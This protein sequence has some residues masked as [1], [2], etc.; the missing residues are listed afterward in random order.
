LRLYF[1]A[2]TT[3]QEDRVF[4]LDRLP[5]GVID[6]RRWSPLTKIPIFLSA[7]GLA[8]PAIQLGP[9]TILR[10]RPLYRY[11]VE[12]ASAS[13]WMR[14]AVRFPL[15]GLPRHG[16]ELSSDA[17]RFLSSIRDLCAAK[18]VRIA[19]S[20]P[21]ALVPHDEA[22]AFRRSNARFLAKVSRF[23][24]VLRDDKLGA[25]SHADDFADTGLASQRSRGRIENP[26]TR[27]SGEE[28]ENVE[29]RRTGGTRRG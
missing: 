23:I 18:G 21:W 28:L 11:N 15:Q 10:G 22:I 13:G 19:Y 9:P 17:E 16:P 20:L 26:A 14:T 6:E 24:P 2:G 7:R 3:F 27:G 12:D 1:S 8:E 4:G 5:F 25:H 29:S